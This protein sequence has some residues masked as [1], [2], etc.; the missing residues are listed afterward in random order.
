MP[1]LWL[2]FSIQTPAVSGLRHFATDLPLPPVASLS[3]IGLL[4]GV[5]TDHLS[6]GRCRWVEYVASGIVV[7]GP[8]GDEDVYRVT[9][10]G[11]SYMG[12]LRLGDRVVQARMSRRAM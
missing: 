6:A 10:D 2:Y 9:T 5:S 8:D 1:F 3:M 7:P 4:L 12:S 11:Q